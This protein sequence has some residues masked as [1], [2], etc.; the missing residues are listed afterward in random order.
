MTSHELADAIDEGHAAVAEVIR[1]NFEPIMALYSQRADITLGNPFGPFARGR[2]AA[3]AA[4]SGAASRY[5]D[6]EVLGIELVALHV[7]DT[8]ACVVEVE[9]F[10]VKV[11]G[12]EELANVTL[13]ATS[14]FRLEEGRWHLVHRHADPI[15]SPRPAESVIQS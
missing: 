7:S 4:V 11:G 13:R 2:E 8:L 5:R 10:R 3:T 14:V 12:R 15:N 6:G 9:R 1:G